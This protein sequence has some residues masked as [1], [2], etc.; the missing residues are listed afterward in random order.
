MF[1]VIFLVG[2]FSGKKF[3]KTTIKN[4]RSSTTTEEGN[5]NVTKTEL[6][7]LA[8]SPWQKRTKK[9]MKTLTKTSQGVYWQ[10]DKN[11][12]KT[13]GKSLFNETPENETK[14]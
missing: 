6:P 3:R 11:K 5:K 13:V 4:E 1:V 9:R 12:T 10:V 7:K 14:K 2:A 8:P